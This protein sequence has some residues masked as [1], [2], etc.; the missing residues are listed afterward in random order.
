M[1]SDQQQKNNLISKTESLTHLKGKKGQII[2][3][4]PVAFSR[5]FV[6]LVPVPHGSCYELVVVLHDARVL[7]P[8][9]R[10]R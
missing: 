8:G 6:L 3:F 7:F 5:H 2:L 4:F 10:Y 1:N 9:H